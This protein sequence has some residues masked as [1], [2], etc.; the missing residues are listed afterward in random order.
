[1][2]LHNKK[3]YRQSRNIRTHILYRNA[4]FNQTL[5]AI[6]SG[7]PFKLPP[8]ISGW[9]F[10]TSSIAEQTILLHPLKLFLFEKDSSLGFLRST[11]TIAAAWGLEFEQSKQRE[12]LLRCELLTKAPALPIASKLLVRV[13]CVKI[14]PISLTM[15]NYEF[16]EWWEIFWVRRNVAEDGG[17]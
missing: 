12:L 1:M 3:Q 14:S 13:A 6:S 10:V 8:L 5:P 9:F 2:L 4:G 16:W 7:A 11:R 15:A 17:G